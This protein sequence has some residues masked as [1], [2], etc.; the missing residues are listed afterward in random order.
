MGMDLSSLSRYLAVPEAEALFFDIKT[1]L[2]KKGA[3]K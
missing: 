1:K 2:H 3:A